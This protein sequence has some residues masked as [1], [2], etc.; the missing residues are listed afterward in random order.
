M[1]NGQISCYCNTAGLFYV[2]VIWCQFP[3]Y[4]YI[5]IAIIIRVK[6]MFFVNYGSP[7]FKYAWTWYLLNTFNL[8]LIIQACQR[9]ST[10]I[11]KSLPTTIVDNTKPIR[12]IPPRDE[13]LNDGLQSEYGVKNSQHHFY[14]SLYLFTANFYVSTIYEANDDYRSCR[15]CH[16]RYRHIWFICN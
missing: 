9:N 8:F 4:I 5:Y 1:L 13:D 14:M 10:L 12:K 16:P 6:S 2:T 15:N 11:C 7:K 3:V